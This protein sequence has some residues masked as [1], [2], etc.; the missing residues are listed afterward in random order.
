MSNPLNS[1]FSLLKAKVINWLMTDNDDF[2]TSTGSDFMRLEEKVRIG[3][4]LLIQGRSRVSNIISLM[5]R[6]IWT[7]SVLY[8]GEIQQIQNPDLKA[9]L[10]SHFSGPE[11]IKLIIESLL[12]KG[13]IVAPLS[14]YRQD[15][16]R[17]CRPSGL[18]EKDAEQLV[19]AATQHIG[20]KY[21]AQQIF[22]L[23]KLLLPWKIFPSSWRTRLF[24]YRP[25]DASHLI[26]STLI[27]EAFH[28]IKYPILP[29]IHKHG[30]KGFE[31]V[32][33]NPKLFTPCDFDYSPFFDIIKYP[34]I[35]LSDDIPYTQI[36]WNEEGIIS[37][38]KQGIYIAKKND[39]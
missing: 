29:I 38:D 35:E 8:I 26:C 37:N 17:I 36:K 5:T 10:I 15:H 6:S 12:D 24:Y 14:E 22:D 20:Q 34:I 33:R 7:H 39:S 31:F 21:D 16:I 9:F 13:V 23:A 27:V 19:I 11:N 4:V 30:I 25:G 28:A 18:P 1:I 32:R 2:K 3:D